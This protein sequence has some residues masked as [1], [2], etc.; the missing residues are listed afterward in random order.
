MQ[1]VAQFQAGH[2]PT[3]TFPKSQFV[4][5]TNVGPGQTGGLV[6][7]FSSYGPSAFSPLSLSILHAV[8]S[9]SLRVI[10]VE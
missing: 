10:V 1:L 8:P 7:T 3:V 9:H 6:S 4:T 5:Q 2:A